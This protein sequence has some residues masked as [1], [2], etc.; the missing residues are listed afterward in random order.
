MSSLKA[1]GGFP[2]LDHILFHHYL[3]LSFQH[4][5]LEKLQWAWQAILFT[6]VRNLVEPRLWWYILRLKN[7]EN[8]S[9][10]EIAS[11]A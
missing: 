4:W 6:E 7:V 5:V 1:K 9:L 8:I 3:V 2:E 10:Q 11:E